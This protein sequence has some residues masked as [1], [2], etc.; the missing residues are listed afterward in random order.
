MYSNPLKIGNSIVSRLTNVSTR[1][2]NPMQ[3]NLVQI[4]FHNHEETVYK[5]YSS[6]EPEPAQSLVEQRKTNFQ[7]FEELPSPTR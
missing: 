1:S 6:R 2:S 5:I 3:R 7:S 4:P